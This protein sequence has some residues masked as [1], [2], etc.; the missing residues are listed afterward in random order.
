MNIAGVFRI[1]EELVA[2]GLLE[3]Y[4]IGG[5]VAAT[6]YLE[7]V[8]TQDVDV[9]V[10]LPS[11]PGAAILDPSPIFAFLS[12]RGYALEGEYAMI[13]GWPVQF[14]APPGPLGDEAMDKAQTVDAGGVEVRIL[15]A[16]H[17]AA[18]ALA[19]GRAK[20]KARVLMFLEDTSFDAT[21]SSRSSS[22]VASATSGQ[23]SGRSLRWRNDIRY[24]PH[25][26]FQSGPP[27]APCGAAIPGKAAN[28]RRNA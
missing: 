5:A 23:G 25:R 16:A 8:S 26:G 9:F 22:G 7:P 6:Y 11:R 27:Q 13:E 3:S 28:A 19:T 4:A 2:E 14:L 10:R 18:I 24:T 1:L 17:L 20:D 15:G 21:S 12:Q